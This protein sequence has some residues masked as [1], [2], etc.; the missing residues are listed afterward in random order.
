M[1]GQQA[2]GINATGAGVHSHATRGQAPTEVTAPKPPPMATPARAAPSQRRSA[3]SEVCS[4]AP[5]ARI[6]S[7]RQTAHAKHSGRPGSHGA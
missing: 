4:S 2:L 3:A 5:H 7:R 6:G 1:R